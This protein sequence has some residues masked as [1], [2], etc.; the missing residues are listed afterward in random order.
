[1][2]AKI[3]VSSEEVA[4]LA[5]VSRS[6]VS[7][8]FT[9]GAYVSD[10]TRA[11][12]RAAAEALG[13]RPNAIARSL[14]MQSTGIVGVVASELKNP[15][16]AAMLET[17]ALKL[18]SVK[19]APLVQMVET[20][21]ID[22][23]IDTM[24]GYQVDGVILTAATM[25]SVMAAACARAGIPVV[26]LDRYSSH[27]NVCSVVSDNL[28][29]GRLA[30]RHLIDAGCTQLAIIEGL[31]DTSSSA[32]RTSGFLAELRRAG[33]QL[34]GEVVGDYSYYGGIDAA[35]KLL[36]ANPDID[37]IF[38]C[39]DAMAI[40][41][42][43]VIQNELG[44]SI[45]DD[46]AVMGYDNSEMSAWPQFGLTTIDQDAKEMVDSG[47]DLLVSQL[48]APDVPVQNRVLEPKLI[49]RRSTAK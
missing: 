15:Y 44:R 33:L 32:D 8:T 2:A 48:V 23:L 49:K 22:E 19:L 35:R 39:N 13:Y 47:V 16:Y 31:P 7:R 24:L 29:G 20:G 42:I 5:G 1:M 12:V 10:K 6:A 17:L 18:R 27:E 46:V 40:G 38:C 36:S 11:K 21:R 41:A 3:R 25:S 30:A 43:Q 4:R 9:E 34:A 37:A 28:K 14:T 45:P 26:M